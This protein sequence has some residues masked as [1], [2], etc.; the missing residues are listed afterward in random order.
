M[1]KRP[2]IGITPGYAADKDRLYTSR[3]YVEGV[4]HAGGLA[5]I[6]PLANGPG[7]FD[8][9]LDRFDAFVLSGGADIDARYYGEENLNSNGEISP[10]RDEFELKL[11]K[12]VIECGKP[13]L[14][15]CRGVQVLNAALGGTLY[16]DIHSQLK[17][18]ALLKHWQEAPDW[19]PVHNARLERDSRL[20]GCFTK[21]IIKVNSYHH[22][23]VKNTGK[24][25]K[26][27]AVSSDGIIEALEHET[28]RFAVG[29]QWHPELMWKEDREQFRLFEAFVKAAEQS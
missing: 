15:I 1:G 14:A 19:Y 20:G 10:F 3:G 16:Q 24:G 28:H 11:A 26:V 5:A 18:R 8:E 4:N 2:L 7:M 6:M 12:A 13:V 21:N 9:V 17:D 27:T 22:Q 23:A 25:L 29:V